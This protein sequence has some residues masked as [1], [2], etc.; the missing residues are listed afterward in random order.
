MT[1]RVNLIRSS[2]VL[3]LIA[4]SLLGV[5]RFG[6]FQRNLGIS[7]HVLAQRL[8]DLVA[9]RV[10]VRQHYRCRPDRYEYREAFGPR[11]V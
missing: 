9:K 7:R 4:Q 5:R 10:L 11:R 3:E 1:A 2:W 6:E 8:R